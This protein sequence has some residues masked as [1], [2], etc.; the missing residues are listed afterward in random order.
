MAPATN[1]MKLKRKQCFCSG[2]FLDRSTEQQKRFVTKGDQCSLLNAERG[3]RASSDDLLN[4]G[5]LETAGAALFLHLAGRAVAGSAAAA[6][7]GGRGQ[8]HVLLINTFGR[9]DKSHTGQVKHSHTATNIRRH[10]RYKLKLKCGH[11]LPF[12]ILIK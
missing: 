3:L 8:L 9:E 7:A 6:E 12:L 10:Y 5:A 1:E 11:T 2:T 4:A